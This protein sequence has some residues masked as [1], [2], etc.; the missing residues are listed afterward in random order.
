MTGGQIVSMTLLRPISMTFTEPIVLAIDLY[1]GLIYA[2]LYS[3]VVFLLSVISPSL[4][5]LV[6]FLMFT[7][8]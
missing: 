8:N 7:G 3:Y 6:Q 5:D 4:L 2:I 1:I